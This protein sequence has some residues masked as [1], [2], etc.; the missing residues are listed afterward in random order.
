MIVCDGNDEIRDWFLLRVNDILGHSKSHKVKLGDD[1]RLAFILGLL[2]DV[3]PKFLKKQ[4]I[5]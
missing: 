4:N 1:F 5:C 2:D 3:P